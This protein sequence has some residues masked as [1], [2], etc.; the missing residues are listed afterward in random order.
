MKTTL[1]DH[2][3]KEATSL[4]RMVP[5]NVRIPGPL[6]SR[7]MVEAESRAEDLSVPLRRALSAYFAKDATEERLQA[8]ERKI[9][10]ILRS[11]Q[12]APVLQRLDEIQAA[13]EGTG[14][15]VDELKAYVDR[16]AKGSTE[17]EKR[18]VESMGKIFTYLESIRD[19]YV[20]MVAAIKAL[21]T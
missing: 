21:D 6:H 13:Q 15:K 10:A 4:A 16:V 5:V 20:K 11:V 18:L 1:Q 14:A 19:G 12:A 7:F 17:L 8:I 3:A 2:L 9:D